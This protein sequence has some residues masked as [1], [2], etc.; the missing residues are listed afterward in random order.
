VGGPEAAAFTIVGSEYPFD[1]GFVTPPLR[2]IAA[3]EAESF[4]VLYHP[5]SPGGHEAEVQ[6]TTDVQ[7]KTIRLTGF[8]EGNCSYLAP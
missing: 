3:G 5:T 6:I 7:N 1:T 2:L 8:C 4:L